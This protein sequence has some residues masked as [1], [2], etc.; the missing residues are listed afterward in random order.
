MKSRI[1]KIPVVDGNG[2][3]LTLF[4]VRERGGL[5]GLLPRKR[6]VLGSGEGVAKARNG[7]VVVATGEKLT[8]VRAR[9]LTAAVVRR[10]T[11]R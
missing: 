2:D 4:E 8:P 11:R 3:E 9:R 7:Y 10:Q 5:F 6:L 1:S